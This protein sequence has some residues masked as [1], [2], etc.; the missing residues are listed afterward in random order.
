[1]QRRIDQL[2]AEGVQFVF[3]CHIGVDKTWDQIRSSVDAAVICTGAEQPRDLA[4]EGRA[5]DGIHFAM[6]FLPQSNRRNWGDIDPAALH[7]KKLPITAT[8]KK[9]IVIGGGDTGSDCIGT[10]LRQGAVDVVNFEM[11]PEPP[12]AR[13]HNNPWPQW[14]R[15]RR[16]SSSV[17]EMTTRGGNVAFAVDT[18]R[19]VGSN[20]KVTG[21]QTVNLDWSSGKPVEVPGSNVDY[22]CEL[23]L[24]AL[25][26]LGPRKTGLLEQVGCTLDPRGNVLADAQTRMTSC[27]GVFAAGDARRG[28]SLVVWA[29]AEG[30]EVARCVDQWLM[31][32][33]SFL[34]KVRIEAFA[35]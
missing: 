30:R 6:E 1:V 9:V 25:G 28:Q 29:I 27:A 2:Q 17:E 18:K 33:D 24:L 34:P 32:R 35:Y 13:A 31:Q 7:P 12:S 8:G 23:V 15:I 3:N 22:G 19:F 14:S 11:M 16:I 20:G 4:I 10:C 5:L 21:L 26:F